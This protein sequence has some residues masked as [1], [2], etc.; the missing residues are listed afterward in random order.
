MVGE[1]NRNEF[2]C[3]FA[4]LFKESVIKILVLLRE[5]D[6]LRWK[7]IQDRTDLPVAT[8]NRSLSILRE[9]RFLRREE[10]VYKLT[11]TGKLFLDI[12]LLI[13]LRM[14]KFS[15][16]KKLM[17][18]FDEES[19]AS[20]VALFALMIVF[21]GLKLRKS[22]NI[23]EFENVLEGEKDVIY[24]VLEDFEREGLVEFDGEIIE[25]TEKFQKM[26]LEDILSL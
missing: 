8:L 9:L 7:D 26:K 1:E 4:N 16:D 18:V 20:N 5:N 15:S 10:N 21:A 24:K 17:E 3:K 14:D 12:L 13:G 22:L 6:G 2:I 23:K 19:L 11:W 25:A